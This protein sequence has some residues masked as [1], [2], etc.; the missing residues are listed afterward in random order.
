MPQHINKNNADKGFKKGAL[1]R[2]LRLSHHQLNERPEEVGKYPF[3]NYG[4]PM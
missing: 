3:P 2:T 1:K 4:K